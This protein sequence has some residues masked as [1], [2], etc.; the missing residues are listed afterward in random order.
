VRLG[1]VTYVPEASCHAAPRYDSQLP[2]C[3]TSSN[4]IRRLKLGA[5]RFKCT[6]IPTLRKD[7]GVV[8]TICH[9]MANFSHPQTLARGIG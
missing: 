6:T 4:N 7:H 3:A 2:P 1:C 5:R 9:G 8:G